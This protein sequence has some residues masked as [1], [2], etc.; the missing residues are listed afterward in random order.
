M[1]NHLCAFG[2]FPALMAVAFSGFSVAFSVSVA[3]VVVG[4]AN[5]GLVLI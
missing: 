5:T 4:T 2:S 3:L 1:A